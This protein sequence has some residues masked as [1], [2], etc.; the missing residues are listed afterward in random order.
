MGAVSEL[1]PALQALLESK[2]SHYIS[3]SLDAIEAMMDSHKTVLAEAA[4]HA[5]MK[6]ENLESVSLSPML[7]H[8]ALIQQRV[9]KLAKRS[10][11]I[12]EPSQRVYRRICKVIGD[13]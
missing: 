2:Y 5:S 1:L 6:P 13:E 11:D 7:A 4:L 10:D 3:A 12:A 9:G 8:L